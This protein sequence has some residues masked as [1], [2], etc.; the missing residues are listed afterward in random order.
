M[1]QYKFHEITDLFPLLEGN[2]YD[3]LVADIRANGLRQKIVLYD[4]KI[5]DGRNRYRACLEGGI[6][7]RFELFYGDNDKALSNVISLNLKRRHL[8]ES[9][10]ASIA[11]RI[12]DLPH[13]GSSASDKFAAPPT[14]AR[15]AAAVRDIRS[16]KEDNASI[17]STTEFPPKSIKLT[18]T[19]IAEIMGARAGLMMVGKRI[20]KIAVPKL[21]AA[22]EAACNVAK[23]YIIEP[24]Q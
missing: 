8:D 1:N 2:E 16:P 14:Q 22:I 7:P 23:E 9:Q 4:G 3:E 10:R 24:S 6:E 12:A 5:L 13:G 17:V 19:D 21:H 18:D 20:Q 11:G 15:A